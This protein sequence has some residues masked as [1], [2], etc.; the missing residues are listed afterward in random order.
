LVDPQK[1][2]QDEIEFHNRMASHDNRW[3]A[4]R[5]YGL[6][7]RAIEWALSQLGDPAGRHIIDLGIGDGH[8]TVPL[9]APDATVL[10][11]DISRQQLDLARAL[12][13]PVAA[14]RG[15]AVHFAQM[16]GERMPFRSESID[17][18]YGVSVLHHLDMA[19]AGVE[20]SRVLKPGGRGVFVEPLARNPV[21]SVYRRITPDRHS[22]NEEPFELMN[23]DRLLTNFSE[24]TH[25]EFYLVSPVAAGFALLKQRWLFDVSM[26]ALYPLDEQLMKRVPFF[27]RFGWITVVTVVK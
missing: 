13:G 25:R 12:L 14:E 8:N 23:I 5:E 10:G 7:D 3:T 24:G 15:A 17:A 9:F 21:A 26:A 18:V 22:E 11:L 6:S 27:R 20:I 2:W 16:V 4:F 19:L 1:R